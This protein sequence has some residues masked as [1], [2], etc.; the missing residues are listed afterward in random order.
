MAAVEVVGLVVVAGAAVGG[1]VPVV[2]AAVGARAQEAVDP[3]GVADRD[4]V[5][6]AVHGAAVHEAVDLVAADQVGDG[7]AVVLESPRRVTPAHRDPAQLRGAHLLA[8]A[9]QVMRRKKAKK[10]S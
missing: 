8:L 5:G 6:E 2:E 7:E 3:A 1:V 9:A 4:G 10:S